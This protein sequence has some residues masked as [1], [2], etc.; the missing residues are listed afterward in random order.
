MAPEVVPTI[1]SQPAGAAHR[2]PGRRRLG[3]DLI[4]SRGHREQTASFDR[5]APCL[6]RFDPDGTAARR[7]PDEEGRCGTDCGILSHRPQIL[8]PAGANH[9]ISGA[10][11]N[12]AMTLRWLRLAFLPLVLAV[13][14]CGGG[15]DKSTSDLSAQ[16]VLD[17]GGHPFCVREVISLQAGAREGVDGD[18]PRPGAWR[19]RR[20]TCCCRTGS[21]RRSRRRRAASPCVSRSSPS[22][23]RPGSRT[24]SR[25]SIQRLPRKRSI[26]DVVDPGALGVGRL[27][28]HEGAPHRGF[29][30]GGRRVVLPHSRQ[31]CLRRHPGCF[32][33][34]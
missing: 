4:F 30:V 5:Q 27:E 31:D 9:A 32:E 6:R 22:A 7:D 25:A 18:T 28:E 29:G 12:C 21:R 34:C 13:G 1:R 16:E 23:T 19:R 3:L 14:A 2:D 33:L 15:A 24:L 10:M 20:A 11:H 8:P 17:S 26:G